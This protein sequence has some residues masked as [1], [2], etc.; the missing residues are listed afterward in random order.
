MSRT[1]TILVLICLI[2]L[3]LQ[4][5]SRYELDTATDLI[6]GTASL[7]VFGT[8]FLTSGSPGAQKPE[9]DINGLDRF[10]LY[11]G[12]R[13]LDKAG[14]L[15]ACAAL[16]L[17]AVSFAGHWNDWPALGTYTV[18]YGEAFL[19]TTGIKELLKD[20]VSRWRPY[21]Y[22]DGFDPAAA[23]DGDY[24]DSFPSGHTAY[25][26]M[27]AAFLTTTLAHDYA[28]RKWAVPVAAAGWTMA[29]VTGI[30]RVASGEHFVTD[31]LTGAAIGSLCGWIVPW[32]H[33]KEAAAEMPVTVQP[34]A[35]G[36]SFRFQY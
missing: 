34:E 29:A 25:A 4:A 31:V 1:L 10:F 21:T 8:S 28:G 14:T 27:G 7:G 30:L 17:P 5:E 35:G 11:P 26:F 32:L 15:T 22:H 33:R 36:L 12:N 23:E 24:A 6:I 9:Q 20:G 18:M 19:L 16:I 13:T 3:P 2:T